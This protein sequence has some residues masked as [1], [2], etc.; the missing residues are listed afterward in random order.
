MVSGNAL[1][2]IGAS[3]LSSKGALGTMQRRVVEASPTTHRLHIVQVA[4]HP[5]PYLPVSRDTPVHFLEVQHFWSRFLVLLRMV[6]IP[7]L[8]REGVR[9]E[10]RDFLLRRLRMM[11]TA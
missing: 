2:Y 5:I 7:L 4:V 10:G 9:F 6:L 8:E 11:S 1:S 3:T